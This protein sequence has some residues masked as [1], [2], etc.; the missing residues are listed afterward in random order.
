[1]FTRYFQQ[2]VDF[3]IFSFACS[4]LS[5]PCPG[6]FHQSY[7]KVRRQ[8]RYPITDLSGFTWRCHFDIVD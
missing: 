1:M 6:R 8:I 4:Y 2:P 5:L 7:H 3:H